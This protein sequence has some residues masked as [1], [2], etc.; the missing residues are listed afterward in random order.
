[1]SHSITTSSLPVVSKVTGWDWSPSVQAPVFYIITL[2]INFLSSASQPF[3][4]N[5]LTV[6]LAALALFNLAKSVSLL[7]HDRTR[8]QRIREQN[9]FSLLSSPIAWIPP[10]FAALVCGLQLS[11]WEHATSAT[12]EMIDLLMFAYLIRCLLEYRIGENE[13]WLSR[14]ALVYGL[15]ITN[16]WAMIAYFPLFLGAVVWIK[17]I[18]FFQGR[19]LLKTTLLGI[20]GLSLY[21]LLPLLLASQYPDSGGIWDYLKLQL[22]NQKAVLT[23]FRRSVVLILSL[24]SVVP[25]IAMGIRWPSTFGDTS[26]AGAMLTNFMFKVIHI[27]FLTA[28]L[29]ITFD[30]PFS[31]RVRGLGLPFLSFY[32]L[33]ALAVGYYS[34][35]ALLVFSGAPSRSKSRRQRSSGG[36]HMIDLLFKGLV[37]LAAFAIPAGLV[38]KNWNPIRITN[39]DTLARYAQTVIN[40]LPKSKSL[41]IADDPFRAMMIKYALESSNDHDRSNYTI[42]DTSGLSTGFYQKVIQ[43]EINSDWSSVLGEENIPPAIN[44]GSV[45]NLVAGAI[46]QFPVYYMHSSFGVYFEYLSPKNKGLIMELKAYTNEDASPYPPVLTLQEVEIMES[47]WDKFDADF[48]ELLSGVEARIP[49]SVAIGGM[50]AME[51]NNWGVK[52]QQIGE[53]DK[54]IA[55]FNASKTYSNKIISP[56][57]NLQANTMLSK[58]QSVDGVINDQEWNKMLGKFRSIDQILKANGEIDVTRFQN[59]MGVQLFSGGNFRQAAMRFKRAA[60]LKGD[61]AVLRLANAKALLNLGASGELLDTLESLEKSGLELDESQ[62]AE[63]TRLTALA[64]YGMGNRHYANQEDAL[65]AKEFDLAEGLLLKARIDFPK[66][67]SIV[68]T[69][70]QVYLFTERYTDAVAMCDTHLNLNPNSVNARQTKAVSHMR[71]GDFTSAV[72]TLSKALEQNPNNNIA[73]LNRAISFLQLKQLDEALADYTTLSERVENSHA[74]LY[75]LAEIARQQNKSSDAIQ[76]YE[77]Y[78][79]IAPKGTVEYNKVSTV[80]AELKGK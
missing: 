29:W 59:E 54:A 71:A 64:H 32:Y 69:L 44:L 70:A 16:N 12:G 27:V 45:L 28:C 41:L 31:P 30:P 22:G 68:E 34:G 79:K 24:T 3:A 51:R 66:S 60:I 76:H 58:Q 8:D 67:E 6:F 13:K 17:G 40:P 23:G 49:L 46:Q 52:L 18:S 55:A 61:D 78:L 75:G 14:F 57:F 80:L 56:D 2:P 65:G 39:G 63:V 53:L 36:S 42:I 9:D 20:L 73:L 7:P 1:M 15:S 38:V 11:F 48:Q 21:L 26:A 74:V 50:V 10:L 47:F 72:E 37:M 43:S 77:D 35:Y 33:G 19:F 25:V 62:T 5:V 4:M